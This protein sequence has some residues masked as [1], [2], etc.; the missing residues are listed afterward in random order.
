MPPRPTKATK[1]RVNAYLIVRPVLGWVLGS[2]DAERNI[3]SILSLLVI[4]ALASGL[5]ADRIG[6]TAP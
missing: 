4:L 2:I 3:G 6:V 1:G 5:V